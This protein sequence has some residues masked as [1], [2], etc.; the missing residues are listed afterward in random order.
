MGMG[1]DVDVR[2]LGWTPRH[3]FCVVVIGSSIVELGILPLTSLGEAH[4]VGVHH[5]AVY[6]PRCNGVRGVGRDELDE[7]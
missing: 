1:V 5:S 6:S 4:L 3:C 7:R 2:A